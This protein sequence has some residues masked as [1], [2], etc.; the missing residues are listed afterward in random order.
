MKDKIKEEIIQYIVE[1]K[2]ANF[3]D[4]EN[5]LESKG[6]PY[7]GDF[8]LD[9]PDNPTV[10]LWKG[11][12]KDFLTAV[13]E[14]IGTG[15]IIPVEVSRVLGYGYSETKVYGEPVAKEPK[16]HYKEE[17]WLPLAFKLPDNNNRD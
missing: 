1:Y 2:S 12:S 16:Y 17:H 8:V 4:I 7:K 5:H 9:F 15:T 14:L 3:G 10:F 11:M 13:R 6:I